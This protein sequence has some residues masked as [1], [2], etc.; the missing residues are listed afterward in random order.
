MSRARGSV[1]FPLDRPLPVTLIKK[2]TACRVKES[3]IDDVN[4]KS[5]TKRRFAG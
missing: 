2:I 3:R 1:Q 5:N 4:W